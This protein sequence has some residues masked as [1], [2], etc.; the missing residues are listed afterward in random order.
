MTEEEKEL[1]K[2]LRSIWPQIRYG[3][4]IMGAIIFLLWLFWQMMRFLKN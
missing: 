1:I 2:Y 3:I 4:T